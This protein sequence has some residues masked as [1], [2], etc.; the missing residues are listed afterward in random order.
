MYLSQGEPRDSNQACLISRN[1]G[2]HGCAAA[3]LW[4]QAR[5]FSGG[6]THVS[7]AEA[8]A[9]ILMV[10]LV[11]MRDREVVL[12]VA[13]CFLFLRSGLQGVNLT[14]CRPD[15]ERGCA[16]W[17]WRTVLSR[18]L[19]RPAGVNGLAG[20]ESCHLLSLMSSGT[21]RAFIHHALSA[22]CCARAA[23]TERRHRLLLARAPL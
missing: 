6:Q 17:L 9:G 10:T 16:A 5:S 12:T 3:A 15:K 13:V 4:T 20:P 11:G 19:A 1:P 2:K 18:R 14:G 22:F 23:G 21:C 8:G 7:G